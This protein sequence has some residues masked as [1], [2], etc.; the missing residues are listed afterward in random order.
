M[1]KGAAS[2]TD[3]FTMEEIKGIHRSSYTYQQPTIDHRIATGIASFNYRHHHR[4]LALSLFGILSTFPFFSSLGGWCRE[5]TYISIQ[6]SH[7]EDLGESHELREKEHSW[8][9]V[10][11][12][13]M[14]HHPTFH[15]P[16]EKK[17]TSFFS[18]SLESGWRRHLDVLSNLCQS[19]RGIKRCF[20][21]KPLWWLSSRAEQ[22][23]ERGLHKAHHQRRRI[24]LN[25][26]DFDCAGG[27]AHLARSTYIKPGEKRGFRPLST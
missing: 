26:N 12:G 25:S 14:I 13:T 7:Q 8:S 27:T 22:D 11:P 19:K 15:H 4:K 18:T 2:V 6:L 17:R 20:R 5:A 23:Q 3:G 24:P 16:R 9:T 1:S 21:I 10:Y